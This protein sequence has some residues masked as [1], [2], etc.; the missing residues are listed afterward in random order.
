M[1]RTNKGLKQ[2]LQGKKG[3][4]GN[5]AKCSKMYY[6]LELLIQNQIPSQSQI[7]VYQNTKDKWWNRLKKPVNFDSGTPVP[8]TSGFGFT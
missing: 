4:R 6:W 8:G 1:N 2:T 5:L 7:Q 3:L